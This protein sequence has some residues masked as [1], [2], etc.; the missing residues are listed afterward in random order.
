MDITSHPIAVGSRPTAVER[1]VAL[2]GRRAAPRPFDWDSVERRLGTRI[3][4]DYKRLAE[5]FGAGSFDHDLEL[6]APGAGLLDLTRITADRSDFA[7]PAPPGGPE[8]VLI[9]WASTS[10]EHSLCWLVTEH[11]PDRWP[12]HA[13]YDKFDPWERFDCS[14]SEFLHAML[15]DPH[16]PYSLAEAFET[17][18]FTSIDEIAQAAQEFWDDY[19]PRP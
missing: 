1:L 4:Q 2:T 3:P 15:T 10:A 5:A 9:E 6:L 19:H 8:F 13:R 14:A 18:W 16:H 17:H 11:D 12:V 7:D